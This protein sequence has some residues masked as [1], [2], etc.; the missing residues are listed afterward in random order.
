MKTFLYY[1]IFL[2]SLLLVLYIVPRN[3]FEGNLLG[4]Y[5]VH[6]QYDNGKLKIEALR[7]KIGRILLS[8]FLKKKYQVQ[9]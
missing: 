3:Y 2:S 1:F 7:I 8:L 9:S 4:K 5:L 6:L